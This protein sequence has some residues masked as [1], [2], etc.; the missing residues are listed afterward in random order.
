VQ[1]GASR[2]QDYTHADLAPFQTPALQK[3]NGGDRHENGNRSAT[4]GAGYGAGR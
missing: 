2:V 1:L 3:T 4:A